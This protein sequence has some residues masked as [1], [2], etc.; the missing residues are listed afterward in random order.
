MNY[1]DRR[2]LAM[3]FFPPLNYVPLF[4]ILEVLNHNC[5][6][7]WDLISKCINYWSTIFNSY[8]CPAKTF[9]LPSS[10]N[11]EI[12]HLYSSWDILIRKYI[13]VLTFSEHKRKW[14]KYYYSTATQEPQCKYLYSRIFTNSQVSNIEKTL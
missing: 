7:F 4:I 12:F 3:K 2:K 8:K 5:N 11:V 1:Q 14:K 10:F 13:K 9:I 6:E